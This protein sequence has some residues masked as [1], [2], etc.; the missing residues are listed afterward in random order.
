MDWLRAAAAT[1]T[2]DCMVYPF[3]PSQR[4]GLVHLDGRYQMA[5]RVVLELA[6]RRRPAGTEAAHRCGV[7]RCCNPRHLRWASHEANEAD[8]RAH[9]TSTM[10]E[11]HPG[12]KITAEIVREIRASGATQRELAERFGLSRGQVGKIRRRELWQHV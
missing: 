1:E 2:D 6:G 5:H 7:A 3:T 8:K 9:G 12:A 10:G 11:R 4:Y